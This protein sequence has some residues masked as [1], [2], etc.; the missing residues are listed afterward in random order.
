MSNP[1]DVL[2]ATISA[3]IAKTCNV[4]LSAPLERSMTILQ[5]QGTIKNLQTPYTGILNCL[6]RLYREEGFKHLWRGSSAAV[7]G[8]I[9]RVFLNFPLKDFFKKIFPRF[10]PKTQYW[11]FFGINILSGAFAGAASMVFIYPFDLVRI[12]LAS[13]LGREPKDRQFKGF[14]DCWKSIYQTDGIRGLYRGYILSC[15]GI[16][17]YRGLY[18]GLYDSLKSGYEGNNHKDLMGKFLL[19]QG[20]TLTAGLATYPLDTL[21]RRLAM[22]GGRKAPDYWNGM[23]CARKMVE[24][25]GVRSLFRGVLFRTGLNMSGSVALVVYDQFTAS[26]RL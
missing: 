3:F 4:L 18:F 25:E 20:V 9:P 15:V 14:R 16:M 11:Q 19:A 26:R 5:T 22:Q 23:D 2:A 7:L 24:R 8:N 13:D 17:V 21:R 10:D 12:Q 6:A 1:Q